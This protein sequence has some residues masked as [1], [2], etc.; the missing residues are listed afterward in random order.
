MD[1]YK[2][3]ILFPMFQYQKMCAMQLELNHKKPVKE[4]IEKL[5][6]LIKMMKD[7]Q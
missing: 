6:I 3:K 5:D 7:S 1:D 2:Y 4:T